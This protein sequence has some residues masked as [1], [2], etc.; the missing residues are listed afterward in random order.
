M[1]LDLPARLSCTI[2]SKTGTSQ[3]ESLQFIKVVY[4]FSCLATYLCCCKAALV[5][6]IIY[7]VVDDVIPFRDVGSQV[8]WS[9]VNIGISRPVIKGLVQYL[10]KEKH[11]NLSGANRNGLVHKYSIVVAVTRFGSSSIATPYFPFTV[12][13]ALGAARLEGA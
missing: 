5:H 9:K 10:C 12:S 2:R 6:P 3:T 7:S 1:S 11:S 4:H 8:L 13:S